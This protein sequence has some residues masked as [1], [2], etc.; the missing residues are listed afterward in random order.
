MLNFV[1]AKKRLHLAAKWRYIDGIAGPWKLVEVDDI[2]LPVL[3][4][5]LY[6][7]RSVSYGQQCVNEFGN[8][9]ANNC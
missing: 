9:E 1:V 3:F 2:L 5:E 8:D 7:L 6:F 4:V